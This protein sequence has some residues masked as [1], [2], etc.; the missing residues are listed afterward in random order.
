VLAHPEVQRRLP[1]ILLHHP[2]VDE[3]ARWHQLRD[4]LVDGASLRRT[5]APLTRGVVLFGHLHYRMRCALSTEAG[6]LE[7]IGASGGALDHPNTAVRSGFNL[8][9]IEDDGSLAFA[10]A[11]VLDAAGRGF[12][13][14]EI[15]T[16][17]GCI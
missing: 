6:V 3:R 14:M 7:V 16:R 11:H 9:G 2:P 12:D 10:E 5:L 1:L 4:G 8:Y 17:P 13:R 15:A